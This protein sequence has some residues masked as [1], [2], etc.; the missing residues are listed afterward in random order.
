MDDDMAGAPA[1]GAGARVLLVD[2]SNLAHGA[3]P[4]FD[5]SAHAIARR[6]LSRTEMAVRAVRPTHVAFAFDRACRTSRYEGPPDRERLVHA[7]LIVE[8]LGYPCYV[9]RAGETADRLLFALAGAFERAGAAE[10]VV[11][12]GDWDLAPVVSERT[13]YLHARFRRGRAPAFTRKGMPAARLRRSRPTWRAQVSPDW[14][15]DW[16]ALSGG[17]DGVLANSRDSRIDPGNAAHLL[18]RFG[19]LDA[20]FGS[21]PLVVPAALRDRLAAIEGAVHDRRTAIESLREAD[22]DVV[23]DGWGLG[24]PPSTGAGVAPN[25]AF[26]RFSPGRLGEAGA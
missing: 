8:G 21:L 1:P 19:S 3:G 6:A 13:S 18:A 7:R 2:F 14:H 15:D 11:C 22:V 26:E 20:L 24:L 4:S 16:L 9:A 17:M 12:S 10:V 5:G 25:P 23:L